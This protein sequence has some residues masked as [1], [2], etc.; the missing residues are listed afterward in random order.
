MRK[1]IDLDKGWIFYR[2]GEDSGQNVDI[3]HTWNAI[4][5]QDGGNDYYRGK[6]CYRKTFRVDGAADVCYLEFDGVNSSCEVLVNGRPAGSHDGG[7]SRF[8][9][10][11]TS[12]L[13]SDCDNVLEVAVD[14]SPNNTVYPQTADFTFYGGI[15]RSV[16]LV[17]LS[18][19]HFSM[20]DHGS[21]G[22]R[23]TPV[24]NGSD[25]LVNV[26]ACVSNARDCSVRMQ[27]LDCDRT[28]LIS[29]NLHCSGKIEAGFTLQDIVLWDGLRNPY[30]YTLVVSIEDGDDVMDRLECRFGFRTFHF[31][32]EKGFFLNG[33]SYPLR[34]V[35]RHQDYEGRGNAL[36]YE[37]HL[38]D[39]SLILE[40]GANALRLSHYQHAQEVY[41]LCD[42]KG[43]VVWA[44]IPYI[45]RHME[46]GV[47][48]TVSQMRE[49]ISQNYNHPSIACWALSNEI[50]AA[51][52]SESLMENNRLLNDI[53]HEM[54]STRATVMAHAFMLPP[55]SPLVTVAD[56]FSYNLYYGWYLGEI[57]DNADFLDSVHR[58]Y[59]EKAVGLSEY[60]AD[61]LVSLQSDNPERGDCSETYQALYH[62]KM[63][64]IIS[65]RPY[66]WCTF[67][68]N[69]FDFGADAREIGNSRG[70]NC[71]GLVT[72]DRKTKKDS[73]YVFKAFFSKEPFVHIAGRRFKYRKS[74]E[75]TVKVYS[76]LE[77]VSLFNNG[78]LIWTAFADKVFEFNITLEDVNNLRAVSG[79]YSDEIVLYRTD[80]VQTQYVLENSTDVANWFDGLE[81]KP[82]EDHFTIFD[83]VGAVADASGWEPIAWILERRDAGKEGIAAQVR[84]DPETTL[85]LIGNMTIESLC[86]NFKFDRTQVLSV[87]SM[88]AKIRK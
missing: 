10:D 5:G 64:R 59:P 63:C 86:K 9:I 6:C 82:A 66:L 77:S 28:T 40:C 58:M 32:P 26:E 67:L 44:E 15:Y 49:L 13:S 55:E 84:I 37:D 11:V 70:K 68:W 71:K 53:C 50:S 87:N 38:R 29:Q 80:E 62:E 78:I 36:S 4:D 1:T 47:R 75:I 16:R 23:V 51:G 25:G 34:G 39:I 48:N 19:T 7:Y 61:A 8:R 52:M 20:D 31:D 65:Q 12:L 56:V 76:N 41:D 88:L 74:S 33:R 24:V 35:S 73:F 54:D 43:L 21:Q 79:D 85:R 60:G 27:I 3:P 57:K 72:F 14:N 69:M 30:L 22:L 42:E 46:D 18:V 45:S 2:S 81:I 17:C 83:T